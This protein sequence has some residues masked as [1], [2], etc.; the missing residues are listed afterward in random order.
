MR[1]IKLNNSDHQ[2]DGKIQ[3]LLSGFH[4]QDTLS[5]DE[6]IDAIKLVPAGHLAGLKKI[7]YDPSRLHQMLYYYLG[8]SPNLSSLGEFIQ[9]KRQV[10][11]YHFHSKQQFY[12]TLFHEIGH[13]VYFF[14]IN[15]HVKKEWATQT[16]KKKLFV[17]EYAK[18]N[19]AE[20]FAECYSFYLVKNYKLRTIKTKYYFMKQKVFKKNENSLNLNLLI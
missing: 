13:Y 5:V 3:L 1:K 6:I 10:N 4:Q 17:S 20:D 12:H 8:I 16:H 18:K 2:L 15:S 14:V 9:N 7:H 11:V 19:A